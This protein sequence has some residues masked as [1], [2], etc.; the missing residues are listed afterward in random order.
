MN[1]EFCSS[2]VH[3]WFQCPKKPDGWKPARLAKKSGSSPSAESAKP[4]S[5]TL[6]KVASRTKSTAALKE[7]QATGLADRVRPTAVEAVGEGR[8]RTLL[9]RKQELGTG[10]SRGKKTPVASCPPDAKAASVAG[11]QALPVDTNSLR[12]HKASSGNADG[13]KPLAQTRPAKFNKN[14]YQKA[15]MREV[16]RPRLKAKSKQERNV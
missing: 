16:Y 12:T 9:G 6:G 5:D 13:G 2:P 3:V 1:C 11:T 8:P 7:V 4:K 10:S 15:Y 14:E